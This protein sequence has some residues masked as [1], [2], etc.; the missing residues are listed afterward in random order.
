MY[1][2]AQ[3]QKK[4]FLPESVFLTTHDPPFLQVFDWQTEMT[5]GVI[6]MTDFYVKTQSPS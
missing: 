4:V 6:R 5:P 3:S 1:P 2:T